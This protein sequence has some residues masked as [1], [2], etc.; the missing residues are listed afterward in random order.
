[1]VDV[2][3][4][5]TAIDPDSFDNPPVDNLSSDDDNARTEVAAS[6]TVGTRLSADTVC[7]D[8]G[9]SSTIFNSPNW[10]DKLTDLDQPTK[11]AA[12]SSNV[13]NLGL[14]GPITLQCN[15][16]CG[17]LTNLVIHNVVFSRD[18]SLNLVSTGQLRRR[19]VVIDGYRDLLVVKETGQEIAQIQWHGDAFRKS[20]ICTRMVPRPMSTSLMRS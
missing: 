15:R 1:M 10:F 11:I 14:G 3:Y 16:T 19:G 12:A 8:S 13:S 18:T 6:I 2:E 5:M 17:D 7:L 9:A 20:P 4:V